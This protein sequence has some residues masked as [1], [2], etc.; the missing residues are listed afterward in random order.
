MT[1]YP[2]LRQRKTLLRP[3]AR[4]YP[5]IHKSPVSQSHFGVHQS[6]HLS[7]KENDRK[8]KYPHT[9]DMQVG[10]PGFG[11]DQGSKVQNLLQ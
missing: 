7:P 2:P 4:K 3:A 1:R 9:T 10:M 8:Q 11:K 6:P 5:A